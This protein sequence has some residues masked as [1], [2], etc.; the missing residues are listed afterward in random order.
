MA[1][2]ASGLFTLAGTALGWA[3]KS[4][5][6]IGAS[7]RRANGKVLAGIKRIQFALENINSMLE[8]ETKAERDTHIDTYIASARATGIG[9]RNSDFADCLK[10]TYGARAAALKRSYEAAAVYAK[11]SKSN[12]VQTE[13]WPT[14]PETK[15]RKDKLFEKHTNEL[16]QAILPKIEATVAENTLELSND[17]TEAFWT[18]RYA[19]LK[20]GATKWHDYIRYIDAESVYKAHIHRLEAAA[21]GNLFWRALPFIGTF[22]GGALIAMFAL[23][24]WPS[25]YDSLASVPHHLVGKISAKDQPAAAK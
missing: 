12:I 4:A 2:I 3:L 14:L 16:W 9:V 6:S 23:V 24:A 21:H 25:L 20:P 7:E 1:E 17:F 18:F 10:E 5:G 11:D 15:L 22:I 8:E 13:S 19:L